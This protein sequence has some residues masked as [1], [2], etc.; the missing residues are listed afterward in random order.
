VAG[1][2]DTAMILAA[3]KGTRLYPLTERVPKC[4]VPIG[5]KPLLED[6]VRRLAGQGVTRIT[7]NLHH[8]GEVI[9]GHFGD[10]RRFGV[11][12][13]YSPEEELLGTAGGVKRAFDRG[14]LGDRFFVWYGDNLSRCRLA[15]LAAHHRRLDAD[16]TIALHH[17][18]DP[19][20]SGIVGLDDG[21]RITR[22][23]EK[24]RPEEIFSNWVNAGI[25]LVEARVLDAVPEGFFDFG[26]DLFPRLLSAGRTLAGYRMDSS[27]DLLWVDS[28][29]DL[30]RTEHAVA[31]RG[32]QE[33]LTS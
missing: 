22:F 8:L 30:D 26:R 11:D 21:G 19:T 32:T 12:L 1:T 15:D 6:T 18:D 23:L 27:E 33:D 16:V 20:K 28:P 31:A 14:L 25:Y 4:M 10:G 7:I 29:E 9:A 13:R 24:P 5:G 2:P 3:G 17:R